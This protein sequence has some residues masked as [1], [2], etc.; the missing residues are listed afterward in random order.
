MIL[1]TVCMHSQRD[2]LNRNCVAYNNECYALCKVDMLL[3]IG[4]LSACY[5]K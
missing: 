3:S 2:I 4:I 1:N 5:Q